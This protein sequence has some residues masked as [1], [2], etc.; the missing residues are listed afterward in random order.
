VP[1][2]DIGLMRLIDEARPA[3]ARFFAP[4]AEKNANDG[5]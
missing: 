4:A 3:V 1:D 2:L 5:A